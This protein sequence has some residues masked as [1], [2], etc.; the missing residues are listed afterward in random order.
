MTP[1]LGNI[2]IYIYICY[3]ICSPKFYIKFIE[4]GKWQNMNNRKQVLEFLGKKN[5]SVQI[6]DGCTVHTIRM[7]ESI[8]HQS[9]FF[10]IIECTSVKFVYYN[11]NTAQANQIKPVLAIYFYN[12]LPFKVLINSREN[13]G[14]HFPSIGSQKNCIWYF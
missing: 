14:C 6:S 13:K 9:V 1:T 10:Y 4:A 2:N 11:R 5:S 7:F 3:K 8:L 12:S